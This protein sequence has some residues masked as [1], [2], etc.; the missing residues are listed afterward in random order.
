MSITRTPDKINKTTQEMGNLSFDTD[1]NLNAFEALVY[2]PSLS[3][4]D[5]M[6]QPS[7]SMVSSSYDYVSTAYPDSVTEI[8]TFKTGGSGGTTVA[9]ITMVYTDAT[10]EFISTITKV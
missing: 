10:K 7:V 4:M 6:I 2:N 5:R 8:Y 1:F 3:S 9:T